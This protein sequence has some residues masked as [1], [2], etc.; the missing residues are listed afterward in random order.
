MGRLGVPGPTLMVPSG[1]YRWAR[2]GVMVTLWSRWN[3]A[4]VPGV[5]VVCLGASVCPPS[6][7]W[8]LGFPELE[9]LGP[10]G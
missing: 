1:G 4:K 10:Q 7:P 9:S 3:P 5:Y 6:L 8:G 2:V